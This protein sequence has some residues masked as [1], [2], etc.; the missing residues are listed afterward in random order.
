[1]WAQEW[2][3]IYPLVAPEGAGDIGYDLIKLIAAKDLDAKNM[4]NIGEGFYSS[5]GFEPLPETFWMRSMLLKPEDR[6][7]I[8]HASA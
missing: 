4:V 1:M 3:N 5:L 7:V 8:C 2:G 6:E